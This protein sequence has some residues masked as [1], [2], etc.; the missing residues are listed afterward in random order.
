MSKNFGNNAC[1]TSSCCPCGWM[2][3]KVFGIA[4]CT[5]LIFFAI[6]PFS[7]RGVVW[8]ASTVAGW[9]RSATNAVVERERPSPV[10]ER[11]RQDQR[12]KDGN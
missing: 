2:K 7:A 12:R 1:E 3:T 9:V 5:W 8:T 6:L 11:N 10:V 4:I